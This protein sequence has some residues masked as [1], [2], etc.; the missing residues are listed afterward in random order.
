M[1]PRIKEK[2]KSITSLIKKGIKS[3]FPHAIEP[4]LATKISEPFN[5]ADWLYE[6]KW[7]GYRIVAHIERGNVVLHSRSL[8]DYTSWYEAIATELSTFKN[9]MVVDGEIVVLNEKGHPD[10]DALQKYA[11]GDTIIYYVFDLLWYNGYNLIELSLEQRKRILRNILPTNGMIKYSEEFDDGKELFEKVE[12]LG[13]EGIVCKK[14]DSIYSP[15]VRTKN[16][17]KLPTIKRQEF[18]I[19]GW[20]ES[21]SGRSFRSLLFGAYKNGKLINVGHAGG[22]YK[23]KDMKDILARLKK[24]ETKK[25]PVANEVETSTTPHWRKPELV[26]EF[27][28]ATFT[29]SGKIRKPA[30]FLG[31][32]EDKDPK[33]IVLEKSVRTE[34]VVKDEKVSKKTSADSNWPEL[35]K[36]KFTSHDEII[37]EGCRIDLTNIEKE[38]WHGI[39]K[40]DL[41]QYYNSVAEF[42]LLHIQNR[43]QSLHVKHR[44][45]MQPGLYI[46]DMEGRQPACAEIF[47]VERKHKK[48][49]KNDVIDYLV[50]NNKPT[51]LWM[52]NLGCIDVN[53]WTSTVNDYLHPDF[54]V[55]DLDPSDGDFS[56]AIESAKAAKQFFDENKL[57]AFVKTSGKTGIHLFLPCE[58]F[59]FPEA[60]TIAENI[61]EEIHQLVPDIT[62]TEISIAA[63]GNKLYLDPNQN[64]EAD[65]VASAYSIRPYHIPTVSTPLEWKEVNEK[66]DSSAFTIKTILKRIEKKGE[67]WEGIMDKKIRMGNSKIL[68]RYL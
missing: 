37:I 4:M 24:L 11:E 1:P 59:G 43:P 67:L 2:N 66:L 22:G 68:K 44:G 32:R 3:P 50:C 12:A 45:P 20:T 56:K 9:D 38:Y 54:I 64:D 51:L 18:V 40:A 47:S 16:W 25:N 61:C 26:A 62:T 63:R 46:K 6:I 10:F 28:Y 42:I 7:D 14:R 5:D 58:N 27:K 36:Q 19:G 29:R 57:K 53:P 41:L 48:K 31:F 17:L 33:K 60:R 21:G 52:I 65:T 13:L 34:K 55:I 23:D 39:T 35:E 49:G 15:G 8:Q 30:I